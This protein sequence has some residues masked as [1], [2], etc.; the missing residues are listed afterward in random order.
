MKGPDITFLTACV[1]WDPRNDLPQ[2][3]RC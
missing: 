3:Y 1:S 2:G